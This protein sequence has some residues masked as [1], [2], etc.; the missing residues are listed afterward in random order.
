MLVQAV[1]VAVME[2]VV[3]GA[4]IQEVLHLAVV[5]QRVLVL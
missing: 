5:A 2:A 3:R 4:K 1:Q